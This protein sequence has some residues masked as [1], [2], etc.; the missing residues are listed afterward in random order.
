ME[1]RAEVSA[2]VVDRELLQL[3][4]GK[5][6]Q[7]ERG[8]LVLLFDPARRSWLGALPRSRAGCLLGSKW[9]GASAQELL[10]G[11]QRRL[12]GD[13]VSEVFHEVACD[14]S[15]TA[16][17]HGCV[18]AED[19]ASVAMLQLRIVALPGDTSSCSD[20][21]EVPG[22]LAVLCAA[23]GT[24]EHAETLHL[25]E[26]LSRVHRIVCHLLGATALSPLVGIGGAPALT[27]GF[28]VELFDGEAFSIAAM[29]RTELPALLVELFAPAS[30]GGLLPG[31]YRARLASY[32]VLFCVYSRS[33]Q[34]PSIAAEICVLHQFPLDLVPPEQ[35]C[36]GG[37]TLEEV[38]FLRPLFQGLALQGTAALRQQV[39]LDMLA[40]SQQCWPRTATE[41]PPAA[42]A[43]AAAAPRAESLWQR[44]LGA[45][46]ACPGVVAPQ[47]LLAYHLVPF[48][49]LLSL[50]AWA[51]ASRPLL[52]AARFHA[53][54][55]LAA[56]LVV[57]GGDGS[58][59]GA[60]AGAGEVTRLLG[61]GGGSVQDAL[62]KS[63]F[64]ADAP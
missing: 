12:V 29:A 27:L 56:E 2:S 4:L 18:Q 8:M 17:F 25:R 22:R 5:A 39:E 41:D 36:A 40:A 55:A 6:L 42:A 30:G 11:L 45:G 44:W 15:G 58:A 61:C 50:P 47:H 35:L 52:A 33:T 43:V 28:R 19:S 32:V 1:G 48:L 63:T 9:Q 23:I 31:V 20:H 51:Y 46:P 59:A 38:R 64:E 57:L 14:P 7:E 54:S 21:R 10:A 13:G 3:Q 16:V 34:G 24:D 37:G 60:K 62:E 26:Q 53:G 49:D